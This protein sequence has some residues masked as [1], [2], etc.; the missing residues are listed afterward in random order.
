MAALS[1]AYCP[2]LDYLSCSYC[3]IA[4][5]GS[6]KGCPSL[7]FLDISFNKIDS[8][9]SMLQSIN[10]CRSL[11]SLVYKDNVF[12]EHEHDPSDQVQEMKRTQH[13]HLL[14]VFTQLNRINLESVD[15]LILSEDVKESRKR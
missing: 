3:S 13:R 1:I 7:S 15:D 14:R 6:L 8:L 11:Q 5:L 2:L 4:S 10:N 12:N 9:S